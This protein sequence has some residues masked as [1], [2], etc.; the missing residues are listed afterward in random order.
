[1]KRDNE[2][3][4]LFYGTLSERVVL[5]PIDWINYIERVKGIERPKIPKYC[6]LCFFRNMYDYVKDRYNPRVID[7]PPE[8]HPLYIL[9]YKNFEVSYLYPGIG[10]PYAGA[11]LEQMITLGAE[12]FV[13]LSGVGTL[14]TEIQRGEVIL[15]NKALRDEGTSF[16]YQKPTRCSYPSKLI[17]KYT[18]KSLKENKVPFHEGATWTTD[19]FFRETLERVK[20]FRDEGCICVEMEASALFS[21]A[22]FRKKHIGGI[23][24]GG[25]CVVGETWDPRRE[26]GDT[27]RI[28]KD[29]RKLL[30]YALD[31][32]YL[33]HKE[34]EK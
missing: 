27:E 25:D 13:F 5:N 34:I 22:K 18:R 24:I 8:G 10:A 15:P 31:A 1:M 14:I 32:L 4:A 12:Y 19:A 3:P 20:K 7:Y 16:H 33:L 6:I 26:V 17:L 9:K 11:M 30:D 2:E 21:I 23:F 28:E 29:R